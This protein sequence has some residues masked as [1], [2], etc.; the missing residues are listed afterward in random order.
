MARILTVLTCAL[1]GFQL[2]L[3][4]AWPASSKVLVRETNG[5]RLARGLTPL[6]PTRRYTPTRRDIPG[7]SSVPGQTVTGTLYA[8]QV[9]GN[10]INNN[11]RRQDSSVGSANGI[12]YIRGT[13]LVASQDDATPMQV[14]V[15]NV[16][17]DYTAVKVGDNF[18]YYWTGYSRPGQNLGPGSGI[19]ISSTS[20]T[21]RQSTYACNTQQYCIFSDMFSIEPT[22]GKVTF[23]YWN[24]TVNAYN[25]V[26]PVTFGS[27]GDQIL[28]TGDAG[29]FL[30]NNPGAIQIEIYMQ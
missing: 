30:G 17:G 5:D 12:G 27:Y 9:G 4:A 24:P 2:S 7:P 14:V 19:I 28:F 26:F 29:V 11:R 22:T 21:T 3:T 10:T 20:Q 1:L 8:T 13:S 25:E 15:P 16:A 18:E 23:R 6:P